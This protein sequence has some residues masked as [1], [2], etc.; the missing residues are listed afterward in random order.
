MITAPGHEQRL[1][2]LRTKAAAHLGGHADGLRA[3]P[4]TRSEDVYLAK[5]ARFP[6]G[7]GHEERSG[8]FADG[9]QVSAL[10]DEHKFKGDQG[11]PKHAGA[12][13]HHLG[14]VPSRRAF[15]P[16]AVASLPPRF[17]QRI[18]DPAAPCVRQG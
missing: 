2:V 4:V 1:L 15:L 7:T 14:R 10:T 6:I 8:W 9:S 17:R 16:R 13:L 12:L 3:R 11:M 5:R 18:L